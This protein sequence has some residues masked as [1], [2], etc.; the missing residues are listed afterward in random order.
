MRRYQASIVLGMAALLAV[1]CPASSDAFNGWDY[2]WLGVR[3]YGYSGSLYGLGRI[4]TP[5]YFAL[6]PPVYYGQRHFR[7]YGG[8]PFA[9]SA[10]TAQAGVPTV[11]L[12]VNPFVEQEVV[13]QGSGEKVTAAAQNQPQMIMNPFYVPEDSEPVPTQ[14]EPAVDNG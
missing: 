2:D 13:V 9:R 11:Q 6:H 8:S 12:I 7:D 1:A 10:Q 14:P 3:G 4:P 5:P